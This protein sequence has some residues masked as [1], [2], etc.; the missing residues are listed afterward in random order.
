[1]AVFCRI[2]H[3]CMEV[4]MNSESLN[5]L[6]GVFQKITDPRNPK[7]VRHDFH[8]MLMLVF[9]GL[10]AQLPYIAWTRRWAEKYWYI[11]RAPLGFKKMKPPVET[12]IARALAGCSLESMQ[13][14]FTEFLQTVL[15]ESKSLTETAAGNLRCG[16]RNTRSVANGVTGEQSSKF[17]VQSSTFNVPN[18]DK[19]K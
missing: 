2:T 1:M 11:L 5:Q 12:T 9:L 17:R 6:F 16:R 8:G 14:A 18:G 13:N 7:G 3:F 19:T 10:L 15:A 4:V